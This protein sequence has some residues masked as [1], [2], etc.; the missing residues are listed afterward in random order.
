VKGGP[1]GLNWTHADEVNRELVSF[2]K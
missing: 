1:H 2:L